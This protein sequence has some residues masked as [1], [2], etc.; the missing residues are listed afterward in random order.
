MAKLIALSLIA[1]G[2]YASGQ[3]AFSE[4]DKFEAP[5]DIAEKMLADKVAKIDGDV[6]ADTKTR[7]GKTTRARLLVNSA[8][9]NANDVVDLEAGPLKEAESAGLADSNKAAVAYA[10]TLEQNKS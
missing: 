5:E 2:A 7:S 1:A 8:L 6:A 3:P 9:G 10:L 4:G